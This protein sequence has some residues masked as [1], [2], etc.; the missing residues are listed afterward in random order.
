MEARDQPLVIDGDLTVQYEDVGRQGRDRG[1][2]VGTPSS[3][4][5]HVRHQRIPPGVQP[6]RLGS[7]HCRLEAFVRLRVAPHRAR[8]SHR[9]VNERGQ[10]RKTRQPV[11]RHVD[12]CLAVVDLP[13]VSDTAS[14][15]PACRRSGSCPRQYSGRDVRRVRLFLSAAANG[16]ETSLSTPLVVEAG[17]A[18]DLIRRRRRLERTRT[19]A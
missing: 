17:G 12:A 8:L 4:L 10:H 7:F 13:K 1:G 9:L 5:A 19:L 16:R 6:A 3:H 18:D 15:R 2:R 11:D 14:S